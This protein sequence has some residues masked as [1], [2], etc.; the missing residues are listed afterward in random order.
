MFK[1]HRWLYH[2]TLGSRVIEEEEGTV[3]IACR[4]AI[5]GLVS[6]VTP[7]YL[8]TSSQHYSHLYEIVPGTTGRLAAVSGLGVGRSR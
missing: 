2:S 6:E 8:S 5:Q 7:F 4:D 3:S 1:T